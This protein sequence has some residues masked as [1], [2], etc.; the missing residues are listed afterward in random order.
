MPGP[1]TFSKSISGFDPR[2]LPGCCLWLDAA[3]SNV[4]NTGSGITNGTQVTSWKDK[5]LS[6]NNATTVSNGTIPAYWNTNTIGGLPAMVMGNAPQFRGAFSTRITGSN[7]SVF[8]VAYT[9]LAMPNTSG[10]DQR[11]VSLSFD[12]TT[13]A[14]DYNPTTGIMA[15]D[16]QY[17][18]G[19]LTT[20]YNLNGNSGGNPVANYPTLGQS[21]VFIA[22]MV[23]GAGVVNSWYNG[24]LFSKSGGTGPAAN[25]LNIGNY[26]V[27]GGSYP[28]AESWFGGIGEVIIYSN[29]LSISQ[30][31]AVEGYLANKWTSKI[32]TTI[33]PSISGCVLWLDATDTNVIT[34]NTSPNVQTWSDKSGQGNNATGVTGYLPVLS[35][36]SING[37]NSMYLA[38]TAANGAPGGSALASYGFRGSF[39]T[40]ITGTTITCFSVASCSGLFPNQREERLLSL[41]Q[42]TSTVDY[43]SAATL[44]AFNIR[45]TSPYFWTYRNNLT[46]G[47]IAT[48]PLNTPTIATTLFDGSFG[49]LW[50]NGAPASVTKT[51]STGNFSISVYGVGL[52]AFTTGTGEGWYGYIGETIIYNTA[53]SIDQINQIQAYLSQKW[54][55]P[56][57]STLSLPTIHPFYNI[58]PNTRIFSPND[59]AGCLLWLDGGDPSTMTPSTAIGGTSITSWIDKSPNNNNYINGP[60]SIPG[61]TSYNLIAPTYASGGGILFNPSLSGTFT[62]GTTQGFVAAGGFPL[63]V[64]GFTAFVV[65]RANGTTIYSYNSYFSWSSAVEFLDFDANGSSTSISTDSANP[66]VGDY[67]TNFT[68]PNSVTIQCLQGTTSGAFTYVNGGITAYSSRAWSYTQTNTSVAAQMWIGNQAPGNRTF[69]G[70]IYEMILYNT[71]LSI[72]QRQQIEGYLAWKWRTQL[73]LPTAHSFYNFLPSSAIPFLPTN[74]GGCVLWLDGNDP[75]GTGVIPLNASTVSSWVDKSGYNVTSTVNGTLTYQSSFA[76]NNGS[77]KFSGTQYIQNTTFTLGLSTKTFFMVCSSYAA[78]TN[79]SPAGYI[80]FGNVGNVYDQQN[81]TA[82]QGPEGGFNNKFGFLQGYTNGGYYT[83]YGGAAGETPLGIYSDTQNSTSA[84]LY[85]N[86]SILATNTLSY[87]PGLATGFRIGK[88][89]DNL[90]GSA[91]NLY[92]NI[93]EIIV[94]NSLLTTDQRQKVEGYLANK[95]GLTNSLL[96]THPYKKFQPPQDSIILPGTPVLNAPTNTTSTLN[97]SWNAGSGGTPVTYTVTVYAGGSLV[98]GT[99]GTQTISHPTTSTTFSPM[100]A[101]TSYTFYVS[102]TNGGGTSAT[103]G[104]SSSVIYTSPPGTPVSLVASNSGSTF[105]MSWLSGAGGTPVT[106]TVTVYAGASLVATQTITYPTISSTYS[107]MISGT[108]YKFYVSATNT[109]GTSATAGPS[110]TVTY[111]A[112]GGGTPVLITT[113]GAGSVILG[114]GTTLIIECWGG[115]GGSMGQDSTTGAGAGGAYSKTTISISGTPTLYYSVGAGGTGSQTSGSAGGSTW[116]NIA[117]NASPISVSQGALASG[118]A[119]SGVAGPNNSSQSANSVGNT[120]YIGGYGGYTSVENGGGGSASSGGNGSPGVSGQGTA[121]GS[122]GT[123][124]GAGGAGGGTAYSGQDGFSSVEGG[125][126]GGGSYNNAGGNGGVPGGAGGM[127]WSIQNTASPGPNTNTHGYGGNGGR[128]QI[129]YTRS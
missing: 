2:S 88:R 24:V 118:G 49:Y 77:I 55:I 125:G 89:S 91:Y 90:G 101:G 29:D 87:T 40:G 56:V 30:R 92:G 66:A 50:V 81:G 45:P 103:A 57:A 96:S 95:W 4:V 17:T 99:G 67:Q 76:N 8:T 72:S 5:S 63:N 53:L 123:N 47:S 116:A 27:G 111:T 78:T 20:Y 35:T 124:G 46:I 28:T 70:T 59:I 34:Y 25:A 86:G 19:N 105:N 48:F 3:D 74:I 75:A 65:A 121:G 129:R 39:S 1:A 51:A 41:S 44:T 31:Q 37:K 109:G 9:S 10:R 12:N 80:Y 6:G 36:G 115:G 15:F 73:S 85:V 108:G 38:N 117:A 82:Y 102:A 98:T 33:L 61:F 42:N 122:S 100:T 16:N 60:G 94:F 119:G 71:A 69:S 32:T 11:L 52:D 112:S 106:F 93:C 83:S 104:P 128:G 68:L 64:T 107:P 13:A 84:V 7:I 110:S 79:G 23:A 58:Q 22:S 26:G 114:S 120:V 126:G 97:M 43:G 62:N 14:G 21:N 18:L 54:K 113:V 127:G